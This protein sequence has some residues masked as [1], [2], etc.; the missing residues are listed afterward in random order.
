MHGTDDGD[1]E[2]HD[3]GQGEDWTAD[4]QASQKKPGNHNYGQK[5]LKEEALKGVEGHEL[6]AAP[7]RDIDHQ[8]CDPSEEAER[9]QVRHEGNPVGS[10]TPFAFDGCRHL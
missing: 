3:P 5:G 4:P 8:R 6:T 1:D 10:R 9:E 2:A 7:L